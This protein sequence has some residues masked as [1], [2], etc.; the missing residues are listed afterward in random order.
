MYN[1]DRINEIK[2][3]IRHVNITFEQL[4]AAMEDIVDERDSEIMAAL[5]DYKKYCFDEKSDT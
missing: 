4:V 2:T 1:A 5:D 3:L